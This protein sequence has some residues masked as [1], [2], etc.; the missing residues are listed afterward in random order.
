MYKESNKGWSKHIDFIV[1]DMISL[2]I[3]FF[4]AYMIRHGLFANLL[5]RESYFRMI[6]VLI[7]IDF[8]SLIVL[9]TLSGVLRRT[10]FQE[11][12]TTLIQAFVVSGLSV[13]YL[14]SIQAGNDYSRI[15]LGLTGVLYFF[16]SCVTRCIWKHILKTRSR[17]VNESLLIVT[18]EEDAPRMIKIFKNNNYSRAG[19]NGVVLSDVSKIGE[20]IEDIQIVADRD[21]IDE[22][23]LYNWVDEILIGI[24]VDSDFQDHLQRSCLEMGITV[25]QS[26]IEN[27]HSDEIKRNIETVGG[28]TVIT[29]SIR[30]LT[31][32]E[33]FFKRFMDIF[34][35]I[36]GCMITG[37]LFVFIGPAIYIA[38]PGPIF[39][40]QERV[41]KNGKI[42][43]MYKFRSMYLDAEER[44]KDLLDQNE[45]EDNYMFKI[46]N[47]PRIIGSEKGPGKGIG[48]FI[49]RTSIDEFP[50]FFNVI[51]GDM[52][53]I[54]TRP[55]L[56]SEVASYKNR[57][58]ARLAT[59]PGITGLWQVSGR[60]NIT[61]FEEVVDL[62]M[63]YIEN[64]SF[65]LD[66]KI[67]FKTVLQIFKHEGAV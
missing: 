44:L 48:N 38:S 11:F 12:K 6:F 45:R 61:D 52:S 2:E 64:W 65:A 55:P 10:F 51:M 33:L 49:R 56:I 60:S 34:G 15:T 14:F 47:D 37:I 46:E 62:D 39:F 26:L 9:R 42:F 8:V 17:P 19:I 28:Y 24:P 57:H 36:V 43:K 32:V 58:R 35:G 4:L 67:L 25:H 23:I 53:I 31:P 30:I 50:Q 7:L 13:L 16:I 66:I 63:E 18:S 40:S 20:S 29:R 27:L 1:L 59:K 22:Y 5:A 21:T 54:G 3:A 41:G